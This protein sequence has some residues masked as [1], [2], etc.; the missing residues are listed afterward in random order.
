MLGGSGG[1]SRDEGLR[2]GGV[3]IRDWTVTVFVPAIGRGRLAFCSS[4][5][6]SDAWL[7]A[8]VKTVLEIVDAPVPSEGIVPARA[9][10][11]GGEVATGVPVDA[12]DFEV[13]VWVSAEA[14]DDGVGV[15]VVGVPT[16][17]EGIEP[18]RAAGA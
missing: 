5:I 7:V 4:V 8:S 18:A 17:F 1:Y 6:A 13:L 10:R 16:R 11:D 3:W 9:D 15:H 2:E 12:A 14:A